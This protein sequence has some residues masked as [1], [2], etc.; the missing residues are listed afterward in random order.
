MTNR[1]RRL[2]VPPIRCPRCGASMPALDRCGAC[3]ARYGQRL[4]LPA[5]Y[6]EA[7]VRGT[8][9]LLRA[10]YNVSG[11]LHDPAVRLLLGPLDG[12]DE[13]TLREAIL[14]RFHPKPDGLLLD[15]GCGTGQELLRLARRYPEAA[16]VGVDLSPGMMRECV[17]N[18]ERAGVEAWLAFADAHHLPFEDES[19]DG[20]LHVGGV[21]NFRD[22][23]RALAEA[24]RVVKPGAPVV[25]VDEQLDPARA[26]SPLHQ[27][28]FDLLTWYD[29]D[30]RAPAHLM[31]A[32]A[33]HVTVQQIS[34]FYYA[35]SCRKRLRA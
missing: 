32:E 26:H 22:K 19:F 1:H 24:L 35:L 11:K 3:G 34:R 27:L 10:I 33:E 7:E 15:L 16:L 21:N 20:L 14:D 6:T 18:L 9:R 23:R 29:P 2:T 8:D 17:H 31:P 28:T 5:L 30:P 4:G 25:F 12:F 13:A